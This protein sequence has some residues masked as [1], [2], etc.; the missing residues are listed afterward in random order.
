MKRF[1]LFVVFLTFNLYI[2]AHEIRTVQIKLEETSEKGVWF[3]SIKSPVKGD[4]ILP[5]KLYLD[6]TLVL[7]N[8]SSDRSFSN[9]MKAIVNRTRIKIE[10]IENA[11][12]K[13]VGLEALGYSA[14]FQVDYLNENPVRKFITSSEDTFLI[15][16]KN[17][18]FQTIKE[19]FVLGLKHIL[20]GFDHLSFVFLI[21]LLIVSFRKLL[22]AITSFSISHAIT[23]VLSVMGI[24]K[25]PIVVAEILISLSILMLAVEVLQSK[26]RNRKSEIEKNPWLVTFIFGLIHGLG[27]AD[28]LREFG[29][30]KSTFV[31]ALVSFNLGIE[32]GQIVSLIVFFIF[33][34]SLTKWF[35]VK[36]MYL[37]IFLAYVFGTLGGFW[38]ISRLF[39][40][41]VTI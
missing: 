31:Q 37:Q 2:D 10:T 4:K 8:T 40:M 35:G 12:F 38:F 13:I 28:A 20:I 14:L 27:F 16:K 21:L 24:I 29:L 30:P 6:D 17:S 32:F 22:W 26:L 34:H 23:L 3:C 1:I 15:P 7:T 18:V 9:N 33:V 19:Y 36:K 41:F 11:K 39:S 25:F 5:I